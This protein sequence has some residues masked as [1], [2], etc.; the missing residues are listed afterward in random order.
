MSSSRDSLQR[1][2]SGPRSLQTPA[3]GHA[4]L[5]QDAQELALPLPADSTANTPQCL[6][7]VEAM[8]LLLVQTA[9][10]QPAGPCCL[11]GA[12]GQ[13]VLG[14][15]LLASQG[16]HAPRTRCVAQP[17]GGLGP[18]PHRQGKA[19]EGAPERGSPAALLHGQGL[20]LVTG[21]CWGGHGDPEPTGPSKTDSE[22]P[23][24]PEPKSR[25]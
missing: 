13:A 1:S 15:A 25:R 9:P 23:W 6:T 3:R 2:S 8:G 14:W 18:L 24:P 21:Q 20:P 19:G 17:A 11:R 22:G 4:S 16:A 7:T 10:L 12:R 5:P